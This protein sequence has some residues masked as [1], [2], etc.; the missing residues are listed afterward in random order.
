METNDLGDLLLMNLDDDLF[1]IEAE[2]AQESEAYGV[3]IL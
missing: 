2:P 1:P 3:E